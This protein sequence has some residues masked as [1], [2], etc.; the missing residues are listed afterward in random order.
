MEDED[1][2]VLSQEEIED[3]LKELPGWKFENNKISKE[4]QFPR[5]PDCIAFLVR[6]TPFCEK[7]DHH[8][9]IHIFYKKILFELQRFSVGRRVTERDFIVAAEI[10]RLFKER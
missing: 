1:L 7:I 2:R 3:K 8:P 10:E 4:F 5:F 6:L 9:D